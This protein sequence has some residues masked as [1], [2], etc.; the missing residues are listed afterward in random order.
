MCVLGRRKL[1][2]RRDIGLSG[3]IHVVFINSTWPRDCSSGTEVPF[4]VTPTNKLS[5][6][7]EAY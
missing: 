2:L 7:Y 3:M 4:H 5:Y 1:M 6:L